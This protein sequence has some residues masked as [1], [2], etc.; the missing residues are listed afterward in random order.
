VAVAFLTGREY[1]RVSQDR[2]GRARSVEE[3]HDDNVRAEA[4]HGFSINGEAYSDVSLSA[5]RYATKVRGD[6]AR[7][8]ADLEAGRFG[9]DVLVLWESSRGSRR[10]GEWATLLDLLEDA[11]VKVFVTT[12]NRV[13]DP[14]NWRD[15]KSLLEDAVDNEADSAKKSDAI[16][17]AAAATA[18][19]GEPHGRIPYGYRRRYDERTRKLIAQEKEPAEAAVVAELLDRLDHGH[20][21]RA[22]ARDF[23]E[24]GI[25]TRPPHPCP[26]ECKKDHKHV[27]P[28]TPGKVFE[29]S[30]LR[31]LALR[32]LYAGLRTH[33][34]GS[35]SRTRYRGSLDAAVPA[36]W[37]ALVDRDVFHRVR[38]ML[39][40]P[41]RRTS[42]P[43]RAKHL[44]SLIGTCD[45]CGGW[46]TANYRRRPR[47]EY[48][49][50][51]HSH[52]R[53]DADELDAYAEAVMCGYLARPEVIEGLRATPE[54]GGELSTVRG[55]L[56][57]ARGELADWR[58][59]AGT[60]KVTLE[61]FA[62]IEP[63]LMA[64]ITGLEVRERELSTPTALLVIPPGKD[65]AR[66]WAAAP[67]SAR[68]QVARMLLSPAILGQLRVARSPSPGHPVDPAERVVW[69]RD[70]GP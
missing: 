33:S 20:S 67:M 58:A 54:D 27:A 8:L 43:G 21:L 62:A 61:S 16:L 44:L 41:K 52:V 36:T 29:P 3:Q 46:L 7:L 70:A 30:H 25:R 51:D 47:R 49:C 42:R 4:Q 2:S 57:Q 19:R 53:I 15:R 37:P 55:D 28:G 48:E 69:D 65:V 34:S 56:G 1:L 5:S 40:D 22:V 9:A 35:R 18:A 14:A 64:R 63:G 50:R 13:Y 31:D 32:P 59:A 68:R 39:L 12:H 17:R 6:F 38:N 11:G 66:R 24:R 10:V 60:G 26:E 23:E 45:E